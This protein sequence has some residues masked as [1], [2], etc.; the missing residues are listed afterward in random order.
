VPAD[1]RRPG[2]PD[3]GGRPDADAY[4]RFYMDKPTDLP[5]VAR[6]N[7]QFTMKMVKHAAG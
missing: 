6:M 5:G 7:S 2:L 4:E 1:V 3:L